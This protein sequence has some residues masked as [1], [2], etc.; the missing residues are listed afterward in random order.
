MMTVVLLGYVALQG[1]FCQ[2][3]EVMPS[4]RLLVPLVIPR[5]VAGLL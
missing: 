5:P 3:T 2:G 1:M 4:V